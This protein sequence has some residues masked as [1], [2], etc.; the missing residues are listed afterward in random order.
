METQK[1]RVVKM[2]NYTGEKPGY[3]LCLAVVSKAAQKT[4]R[5][6]LSKQPDCLR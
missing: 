2:K 3:S 6:S 5:I 4:S 1:N